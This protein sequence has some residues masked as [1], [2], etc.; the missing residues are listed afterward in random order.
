MYYVYK[1]YRVDNKEV[2]YI[3]KGKGNRYKVRYGRN[4]LLT[5]ALLKYECESEI[6][7]YFDNEKEAF[8]YED[9]LIKKYKYI[10][11]CKC[12]LHKGGAGGSGEYWSDELREEY[13]INNVMKSDEQR[14]RMSENNPMKNHDIA[15]MVNSHRKRPVVIGTEEFSSVND[16]M[17]KFEVS[18]STISQWCTHGS[19]PNGDICYY[20]DQ[21]GIPS[22]KYTNNGQ[23]RPVK[24]K[25]VIYESSTALGHAIGISQTTAA[26]WCRQGR[27]S[28]GVPCRYIDNKTDYSFNTVSQK[29]IPIIINGIH[30]ASKQEASRKLDINVYNITQYLNGN[31]HD[32]NFICKYDNQQPSRENTDNSITEG[33]TTNG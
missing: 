11:Q 1:F 10:G 4:K 14:K 26:R 32:E 21:L 5:D 28:L 3:G 31:K 12:N 8:A 25:D 30:Y 17:K 18:S 16:A 29:Q 7:K 33:S 23:K 22:N 6:I 9:E 24:Y 15:L 27:D 2:L 13:S 20:K 19:N